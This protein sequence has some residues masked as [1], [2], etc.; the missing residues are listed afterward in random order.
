MR[1]GRLRE[2]G[3]D[4]SR[5]HHQPLEEQLVSKSSSS[6]R[7]RAGSAKTTTSAAFAAGLALR[8]NKTVV[9]D[10]DVGLR[11][12]DLIM[13]CERRVVF[14]FVN[15]IKGDARLNQ[16]L[17]KDKR[18]E[19][20]AIL[21]TSADPGQG[22]ADPRGRRQGDRRAARRRSTTSSATAPPDRARRPDGP[23]L[24]RRGGHRHQPRDLLGSRQRPDLRRAAEP[25]APR[26]RKPG[27]GQGAPAAHPLRRQPGEPRRDAEGRRRARDPGHP[28]DRDRPGEP[29][30]AQ[31]VQP[32]HPG[33]PRRR[34]ARRAAYNEA[35]GRFLGE[36]I[37]VRFPK[38]E[39]RGLFSRLLWRAA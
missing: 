19:N 17:I 6:P 2:P 13:G 28:S 31:V 8:G 3:D 20:L 10:F 12:L 1:D 14:D 11:N 22:R 36:T 18:V 32:R 35:V 16:A 9:I 29:V 27:A 15:V 38:P 37:E 30:G 34:V 7:A 39:R 26:R 23:L 5:L 24:R 33:H 21:P 4:V 25:L